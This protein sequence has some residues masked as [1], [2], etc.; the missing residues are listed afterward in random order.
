MPMRSRPARPPSCG[1]KSWVIGE[2]QSKN[3][4]LDYGVV[5]IP[6]WRAGMPRMMLLQPE[7][8]YVNGQSSNKAAA[9]EFVKFL[10]NAANGLRLTEMTGWLTPRQDIDW[11]A[12]LAKT[13]QFQAFVET[14]SD[15]KYYV[16]PVFT[17]FDE[18]EFEDGRPVDGGLYRSVAEG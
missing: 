14:P 15:I 4:K 16:E 18:V 8:V 2:I 10:T 1:V 12:L 3:P 11:K 13:P 17:A 7:G 9:Y 5:P 6:A